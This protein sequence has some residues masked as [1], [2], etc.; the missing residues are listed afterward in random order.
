MKLRWLEEH[1]SNANAGALTTSSDGAAKGGWG[2]VTEAEATAA[3]HMISYWL[4]QGGDGKWAEPLK[5]AVHWFMGVDGLYT[6]RILG[7]IKNMTPQ[8]KFAAKTTMWYVSFLGCRC[9][10]AAKFLC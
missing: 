10:I 9:G 7:V 3:L 6:K 2:K 5:I 4:F 1:D 8:Q